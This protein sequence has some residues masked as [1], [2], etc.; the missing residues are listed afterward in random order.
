MKQVVQRYRDGQV[1]LLEVPP[2]VLRRGQVLVRTLR[3][4]VSVG[5]ERTSLELGRMSL[6]QKARSRPD[7]VAKVLSTVKQRGVRETVRVVRDRLQAPSPLGYSSCGRILEVG[8]E[9]GGFSR[10]DL[11]ACG[12]VG[13]ANHAEVISVPMR[14]LAPVPDGVTPDE[15]AFTTIGAIAVWGARRAGAGLGDVVVVVGLGLVGLLTVQV[16]R[17]SGARVVGVDLDPAKVELG[18]SMGAEAAVMT[19]AE[20][21]AALS[22]LG[23]GAGADSVVVAAGSSDAGPVEL[24]GEILRDRGRVVILGQTRVD[25]PWK[26]YYRK[27]AEVFFSR[28]YGPGRYDPQYEEKG[29]DYPAAYVRWTEQ[30]NMQEFLR[31]VSTRDVLLQPLLTHRFSLNEAEKAYGDLLSPADGPVLGVLFTYESEGEFEQREGPIRSDSAG[32]ATGNSS[33]PLHELGVG[34]IGAGNFARSMLVPFLRSAPEVTLRGVAT[35]TG[36]TARDVA[37]RQSFEFCTSSAEEVISDPKTA[38]VIIS[39]RHDLHAALVE[40]GVRAG[41]LVFV[42]KPLCLT[43]DELESLLSV[44]A[45]ENGKVTVGFNRRFSPLVTELKRRL[46]PGV[47]SLHYSINAGALPEDSWYRDPGEG[48]GRVVGEICHFLD[49][50]CFLSDERPVRIYGEAA[51]RPGEVSESVMI[52]LSLSG[53]SAATIHYTSLGSS[54]YKKERVEVFGGGEAFCLENF[55]RLVYTREGRTRTVTKGRGDKG[56]RGEMMAFVRSALLG[57]E[58]IPFSDAVDAT[59]ATFSLMKS[60]RDRRPIEISDRMISPAEPTRFADGKDAKGLLLEG[61]GQ[62]LSGGNP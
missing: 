42:E 51:G 32:V 26:V 9:V 53:G 55:Q 61:N 37:L 28:S 43:E 11:V 47:K 20:A 29:V 48:G 62:S 39:T 22:H 36:L 23:A 15:A 57:K 58:A 56:H 1:E 12:G 7:Q 31:L 41:K 46:L 38:A 16:L 19:G 54:A 27:E 52:N 50:V 18:R 21:K 24:A 14:L 40:D 49:L 4:A 17:A 60:I 59:R 45:R 6:L 34:L 33:S 10:G 5:T 35:K 44:V 25:L 8:P 2:P 30:R 3:S 13:Y